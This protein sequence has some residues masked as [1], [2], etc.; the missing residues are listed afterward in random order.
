MIGIWN[1]RTQEVMDMKRVPF[2]L[3]FVVSSVAAYMM[4]STLWNTNLYDPDLYRLAVKYR[5]K[6]D[7]DFDKIS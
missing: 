2:A 4:C 3:K 5:H 7:A 1:F 6:F